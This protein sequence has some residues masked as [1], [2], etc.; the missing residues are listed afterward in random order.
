[1]A[2]ATRIGISEAETEFDLTEE[3]FRKVLV[4]ED[5]G[6][7]K[8]KILRD[9]RKFGIETV[10]VTNT[11]DAR[12][13]FQK[14]NDFYAVITDKSVRKYESG[15][16]RECE[17]LEYVIKLREKY[18]DLKIALWTADNSVKDYVDFLRKKDI[19]YLPKNYKEKELRDFLEV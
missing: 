4:L 14:E 19:F 18:S 9:L 2:I 10:R 7:W 13:K 11:E 16:V 8:D 6:Y 17:G 12:K 15:P 1:M 5:V 3:K